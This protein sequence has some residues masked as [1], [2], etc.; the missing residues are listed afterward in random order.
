[1]LGLMDIMQDINVDADEWIGED[2]IDE[3]QVAYIKIVIEKVRDNEKGK[4]TDEL[5]AMTKK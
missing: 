3:D 5:L 4:I 2:G 1:M